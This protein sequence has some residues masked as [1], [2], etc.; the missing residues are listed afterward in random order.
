M[1]L[2]FTGDRIILTDLGF[3]PSRRAN[4]SGGEI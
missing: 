2:P 3:D 1:T 4:L